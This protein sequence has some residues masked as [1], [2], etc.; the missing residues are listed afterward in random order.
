LLLLL[1]SLHDFSILGLFSGTFK[2]DIK[3]LK[4]LHNDAQDQLASSP[5]MGLVSD[6]ALLR[7]SNLQ[8][9]T[10]GKWGGNPFGNSR[11]LSA[12]V[13][14]LPGSSKEYLIVLNVAGTNP[15]NPLKGFVTFHL[16]DYFPN[17][18]PTIFVIGG[19]ANLK[20]RATAPFIVGAR[21]DGGLTRLELDLSMV[22]GFKKN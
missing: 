5:Q 3:D 21:A 11:E 20:L 10:K 9:A 4:A 16:P 6:K 8:D 22:E 1:P 17:P 7:T 19:E 2:D 12:K 18:N 13:T 14:Q 15:D